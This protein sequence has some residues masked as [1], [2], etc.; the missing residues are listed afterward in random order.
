MSSEPSFSEHLISFLE[1]SKQKKYRPYENQSHETALFRFL[2]DFI[3]RFRWAIISFF[4]KKVAR[5]FD[6][7][8]TIGA[9]LFF[10]FTVVSI[11]ALEYLIFANKLPGWVS[12]G[13]LSNYC[14][15]MAL[16][17]SSRNSIWAFL[18]GLSID[19]ALFWHKLF[20]LGFV[21]TA[22]IHSFKFIHHIKSLTDEVMLLWI[23]VIVIA[24][25]A[26]WVIR[27]RFYYCFYLFHIIMT[28]VVLCLLY[29]HAR[30]FA[31][32]SG[33]LWAFDLVLRGILSLYCMCKGAKFTLKASR[34]GTVVELASKRPIISYLPGQ[35][36]FLIIP[37]ISVIEPH[38]ITAASLPNEK[39]TF[40]VKN[41]GDWSKKLAMIAEKQDEIT[42]IVNGPYGIPTVNIEDSSI[43]HFVLVAGG[44]GISF[45]KPHLE[46]LVNQVSRGRRLKSVTL[47]WAV[48]DSDTLESIQF[49]DSVKELIK[50]DFTAKLL[51]DS[52]QKS[53]DSIN[54][55]FTLS[56]HIF[57]K[58]DIEQSLN[59]DGVINKCVNREA[60]N[61]GSFFGRL[62]MNKKVRKNTLKVLCCGP[63]SLTNQCF[64]ICKAHGYDFHSESFDF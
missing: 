33:S 49:S 20:A 31:I 54:P 14:L 64:D 22:S 55:K 6:F 23:S 63:L 32:I 62:K 26:M 44:I 2:P 19:R 10:L 52:S 35:F 30:M 18:V 3:F 48:R 4:D 59:I 53:Q 24:L 45:L 13:A 57:S 37:K 61:L 38:P 40:Y 51:L 46:N 43:R 58:A 21:V 36:F 5:I 50:Q 12:T 34:N 7:N 11:P 27:K 25:L 17:F 56:I 29:F 47:L 16:T 15:C 28:G 8:F 1:S 41:F 60:L 39:L 42:V 9:A